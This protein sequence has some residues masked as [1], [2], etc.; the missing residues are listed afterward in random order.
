MNPSVTHRL[1]SCHPALA[2]VLRAVATYEDMEIVEG[3][4]GSGP[5]PA[6]SLRARGPEPRY[7]AGCVIGT[8]RQLGVRVSWDG[9]DRFT[10]EEA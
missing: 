4:D 2:R 8:A 1:R 10:L 9:A 6:R 7:L 3:Y 5:Y